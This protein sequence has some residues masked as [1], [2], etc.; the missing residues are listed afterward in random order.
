MYL[1]SLCV[2]TCLYNHCAELW[3]VFENKTA[4]VL[5]AFN[6]KLMSVVRIIANRRRAC[7]RFFG[8]QGRS[9]SFPL[10]LWPM[11]IAPGCRLRRLPLWS[12]KSVNF[13][14]LLLQPELYNCPVVSKGFYD[15]EDGNFEFCDNIE[16]VGVPYNGN[17]YP[18]ANSLQVITTDVAVFKPNMDWKEKKS[19]RFSAIITGAS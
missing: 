5:F 7:S 1:I 18:K 16:P 8:P 9:L 14:F 3:N 15:Y 12:L 11:V 17:N 10:G 2:P 6:C 19:L 4:W 13:S